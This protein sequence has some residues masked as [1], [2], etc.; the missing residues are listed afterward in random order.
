ME[1]KR[2]GEGSHVQGTRALSEKKGEMDW[3]KKKRKRKDAGPWEI[4]P[5]GGSYHVPIM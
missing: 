1:K 4:G 5:H 2:R 3:A